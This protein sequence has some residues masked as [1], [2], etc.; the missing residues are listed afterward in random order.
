MRCGVDP[1]GGAHRALRRSRALCRATPCDARA[2][3]VCGGDDR[4][5]AQRCVARHECAGR[6][7]AECEWG[8]RKYRLPR[9]GEPPRLARPRRRRA[10]RARRL[11]KAVRAQP[12]LLRAAAKRRCED[13]TAVRPVGNA[14]QRRRSRRSA[15]S[16]SR[17]LTP[18]AADNTRW[19]AMDARRAARAPRR[20]T[21]PEDCARKRTRR[22]RP[23][24]SD[25]ATSRAI[26]LGTRATC[27]PGCERELPDDRSQGGAESLV[28]AEGH[29][30]ASCATWEP[31]AAWRRRVSGLPAHRL[32]VARRLCA[33]PSLAQ[34]AGRRVSC[35]SSR[36]TLRRSC[37][38]VTSVR[39][40]ALKEGGE[41]CA[42]TATRA[43]GWTSGCAEFEGEEAWK[44]SD[45]G[46]TARAMD[47][48]QNKM[49]CLRPHRLHLRGRGFAPFGLEVE[50]EG[51]DEPLALQG[52]GVR[53]HRDGS[54]TC[55]ALREQR[56][57]APAPT[58]PTANR[59]PG[60]A[61][62]GPARS[63]SRRPRVRPRPRRPRVRARRSV[64]RRAVPLRAAR[65]LAGGA[66]D[67][68]FH[69]ARVAR[70]LTGGASTP[71][72]RVRPRGARRCSA[73]ATTRVLSAARMWTSAR[74]STG[75]T[76]AVRTTQSGTLSRRGRRAVRQVRAVQPGGLR[77]GVRGARA[78]RP[79]PTAAAVLRSGL[80]RRSDGRRRSG[81]S[82]R[83]AAE[84][85]RWVLEGD[86][87]RE[88]GRRGCR[89][90]VP[91]VRACHAL[92]SRPVGAQR[93]G[94]SCAADTSSDKPRGA[95]VT[96]ASSGR[97]TAARRPRCAWS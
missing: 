86:H 22:K 84:R 33:D 68:R 53:G 25:C 42:S 16:A 43:P 58:R 21:P 29:P 64:E 14:R 77:A 71:V 34:G 11:E 57:S 62:S 41:R 65:R 36:T 69:R 27:R 38:L 23:R 59:G 55:G 76:A 49:Q 5:A 94:C 45:S 26:A 85:S 82:T 12:L 2:L 47:L 67:R 87:L 18:L 89:S 9:V 75:S 88:R 19:S 44:A 17:R 40:A 56:S 6:C 91:A 80:R 54:L 78:R 37:L 28:A 95:S 1:G 8:E 73:S 7:H 60:T 92:P 90:T 96:R 31:L 63:P 61:P 83:A 72:C 46:R 79:S 50:V 13:C 93:P 52:T 10:R 15:A 4:R 24:A 30:E 3:G 74:A 70:T 81:A 20:R 48:A 51:I 32:A 97:R 66:G 35:R 39:D